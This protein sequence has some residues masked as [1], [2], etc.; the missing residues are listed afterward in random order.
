VPFSVE[1]LAAYSHAIQAPD[2]QLCHTAAL[3][4][5]MRA[6]KTMYAAFVEPATTSMS[7]TWPS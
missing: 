2:L 3:A 1:V 5:R 6:L 7:A 4:S